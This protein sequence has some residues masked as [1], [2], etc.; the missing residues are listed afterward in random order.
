M[1][2]NERIEPPPLL[3]PDHNNLF[4]LA[5]KTSMPLQ[6]PQELIDMIIDFSYLDLRALSRMALVHSS[7]LPATGHHLFSTVH[8][9]E[10]KSNGFIAL[11]QFSP[12][13]AVYSIRSVVIANAPAAR[14]FVEAMGKAD[15]SPE[16]ENVSDMSIGTNLNRLCCVDVLMLIL[17]T[18]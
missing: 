12:A 11:L 7:W 1:S 17:Q 8:F 15:N 4:P 6:L 3:A 10:T 14:A 16:S 18:I 2:K 5:S 9:T 13:A